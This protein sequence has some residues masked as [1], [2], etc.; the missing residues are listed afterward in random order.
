MTRMGLLALDYDRTCMG[1]IQIVLC[2]VPVRVRASFRR[3]ITLLGTMLGE[4][5]GTASRRRDYE[6]Q[7]SKLI[8]RIA[9]FALAKPK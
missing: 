8:D 3:S 9:E 1:L 2:F 4:K 6:A 7:K 5:P